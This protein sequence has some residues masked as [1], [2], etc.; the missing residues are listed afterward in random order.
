[1]PTRMI[2]KNHILS[3]KIGMTNVNGKNY[4]IKEGTSIFP[5]KYRAQ[6]Q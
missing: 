4:P 5:S 2:L 6:V 3:M 1:M